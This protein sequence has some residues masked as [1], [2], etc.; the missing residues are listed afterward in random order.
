MQDSTAM[1]NLHPFSCRAPRAQSNFIANAAKKCP[2]LVGGGGRGRL[3][4]H[5]GRAWGG[6]GGRG[7]GAQPGFSHPPPVP[8]RLDTGRLRG[9]SIRAIKNS[10]RGPTHT[11]LSASCRFGIGIDV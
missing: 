2:F 1:L 10:A 5:G 6:A 3:V 4:G 7:G 11:A 8:G 9:V